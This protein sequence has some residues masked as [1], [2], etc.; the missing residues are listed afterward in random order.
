MSQLRKLAVPILAFGISSFTPLAAQAQPAGAIRALN[1][2]I[3]PRRICALDLQPAAWRDASDG[4]AREMR[5]AAWQDSEE[6]ASINLRPL[7]DL[8][9]ANRRLRVLLF[10][11]PIDDK[12]ALT[13]RYAGANTGWTL[14]WPYCSGV[15]PG[16]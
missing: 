9:V 16:W 8:S 10:G 7:V 15:E 5:P 11:T 12:P 14:R 13:L 2:V 4:L 6:L 3:A 1:L